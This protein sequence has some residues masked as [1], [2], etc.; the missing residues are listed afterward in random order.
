M[1]ERLRELIPRQLFDVAIQ[2]SIGSTHRRARDREGQ[3]QGRARQVLRRRHHPQAQAARDSRRRARSGCGGSAASTCRRRR[4]SPRCAS[5]RRRRRRSEPPG[6]YVHVPVLPHAVRL[7]RLQRVR[8]ARSPRV[9]VRERAAAARPSSRRRA[10]SADEIASVFLGGGTPTTLEVADL[11]AL[12]AR[13]RHDVRRRARR[14]GHDRGQPRH[15]RP[16]EARGAAR[17]GV[18]AAVDGG[19]VVR[20]AGAGVAR[21]APRPRVGPSGDAR[22]A[23]APATRT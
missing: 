21:T 4:S 16:A 12:L 11:K 13:L 3:A 18:R 1:V 5:T 22:G 9:A 17:G 14:R 6:I 15:G 2:A 20:P 7:L 19:A 10:G 23:S 8:G